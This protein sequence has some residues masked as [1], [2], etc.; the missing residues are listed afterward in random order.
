MVHPHETHFD[1]IVIGTGSGN[2]II[3]DEMA[4]WRIALIEEGVF[5]GTCLNVGCIPTKMFVHVAD[6]AETVRHAH[7]LGVDAQVEQVRWADIRDRVFS[8]IDPIASG[9]EEYRTE[10]CPNIT[11]FK[12]HG[13]F[14]GERTIS[15][16]GQTITGDR[17]VV[18]VGARPHIPAIQGLETVTSHTSNT[19]MRV[20]KLPNHLVIIGGG[21]IA[22]EMAHVFASFGSH[23]TMVVRG[24]MLLRDH[25]H[26]ISTAFTQMVSARPNIDVLLQ[27]QPVSVEPTEEGFALTLSDGNVLRGDTLLLATGRTPNSDTVAAVAGGIALHPDGRIVVDE[28]QCTSVPGVWALGDVSSAWQLKHVANHEMRTVRHNL[29]HPN[30]PRS[31]DHRFVPSAVFTRP[32]IATVGLTEAAARAAGHDVMVKVQKYGDVAYGWAME[33]TTSLCKLVADRNSRKLLGAHILGP[34]SSTLI[35]QLIQGMSLGQT[36]DEMAQGQYWIH[37]ALPEVIE[38][39]LLGLQ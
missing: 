9:G 4:T 7:E 39:A 31:S 21:F 17:V 14:V 19:V 34:Q 2:S 10:R 1:L 18:A 6:A 22:S 25:D 5:G 13:T 32:Q 26:D 23:V 16:N 36:V 33:D 30:K 38:N 27:T 12:G 29:L 20:E 28:H 11:V 3:S 35:Q 24:D 15:V 37:P 8:R